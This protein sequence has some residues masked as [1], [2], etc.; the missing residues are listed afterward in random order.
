MSLA[1]SRLLDALR[2]LAKALKKIDAASMFIGGIAVIARGHARTTLDIDATI[3]GAASSLD[4]ILETLGA[5]HIA[6]R[7]E[8]AR[9]FAERSGVLLLAHQ[10]SGIPID[11]SLAQLGFELDALARREPISIEGLRLSLPTVEDLLIYKILARRP[12]DLEDARMLLGIH[13]AT[14]DRKR[15]REVLAAFDRAT[16]EDEAIR[17]WNAVLKSTWNA[18]LKS[19]RNAVLKTAPEGTSA[20]HPPSGLRKK[21]SA[22]RKQKQKQKQKQEQ[23]PRKK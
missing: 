3:D 1:G 10:P 6:P 13:A 5:A 16:A 22:K 23:K 21:R 9:A 15:I 2:D 8:D 12:R 17:T 20:A 4:E 11:L 7:I 19:T 14:V 18:V